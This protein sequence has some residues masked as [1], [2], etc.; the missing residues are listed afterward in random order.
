MEVI[1]NANKDY[2]KTHIFQHVLNNNNKEAIK[3]SI[4]LIEKYR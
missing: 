4:T 3:S 2:K 1:R